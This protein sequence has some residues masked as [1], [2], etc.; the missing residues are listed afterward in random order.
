MKLTSP[1]GTQVE[2]DDLTAQAL[3]AQGWKPGA[4]EDDPPAPSSPT[5]APMEEEA[6]DY[7]TEP[8]PK[9]RPVPPK[10]RQGAKKK[11]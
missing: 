1:K 4:G 5:T 9:P 6:A 8:A 7:F 3:I 2:V 10:A 11:R